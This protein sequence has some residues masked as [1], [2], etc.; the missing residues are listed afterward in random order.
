MLTANHLVSCFSLP[1]LKLYKAGSI[2]KFTGTALMETI[3]Y[4]EAT[5]KS[6]DLFITDRNELAGIYSFSSTP[7]F[8]SSFLLLSAGSAENCINT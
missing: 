7:A 2:L 1:E 5:E 3:L 8:L 4:F 6:N